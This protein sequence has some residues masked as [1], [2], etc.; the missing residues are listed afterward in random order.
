MYDYV[1]E[2]NLV[3]VEKVARCEMERV[4]EGVAPPGKCRDVFAPVDEVSENWG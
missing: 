1:G 4:A 2:E 3:V